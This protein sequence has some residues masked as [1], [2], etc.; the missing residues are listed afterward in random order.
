[1]KTRSIG[2]LSASVVGLGYNNFGMQI[3]Y[4]QSA[5]VVD[6][7]LD[8]GITLFDTADTSVLGEKHQ[9]I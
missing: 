3:D 1:M 5:A 8:E 2:K 7:A 6:T 9:L 4:E